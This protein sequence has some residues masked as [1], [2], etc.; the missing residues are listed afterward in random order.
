[1]EFLAVPTTDTS[2]VNTELTEIKINVVIN[3][4]WHNFDY[5]FI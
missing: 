1:M 3:L 5:P 4:K 2:I